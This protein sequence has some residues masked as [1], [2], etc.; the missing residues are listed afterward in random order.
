MLRNPA[1]I[2]RQLR[3]TKLAGRF[4]KDLLSD[5]FQLRHQ[6]ALP[7][8]PSFD[9]VWGRGGNTRMG[10]MRCKLCSDSDQESLAD[11]DSNF[12]Q[13]EIDRYSE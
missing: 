10:R 1:H 3:T 6:S 5:V 2:L 9:G 7:Q 12:G 13:R 8:S 4:S 11:K